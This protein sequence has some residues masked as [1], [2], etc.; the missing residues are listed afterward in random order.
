MKLN[1]KKQ[2]RLQNRSKNNLKKLVKLEQLMK[3]P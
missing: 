1:K 3:Q 2:S